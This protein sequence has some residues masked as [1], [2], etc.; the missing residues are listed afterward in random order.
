MSG[1]CEIYCYLSGKGNLCVL[2]LCVQTESIVHFANICITKS[3]QNLDNWLDAIVH[4][5]SSD[6][7]VYFWSTVWYPCLVFSKYTCTS[8][9]HELFD[10]TVLMIKDICL[11]EVTLLHVVNNK[12]WIHH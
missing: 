1:K 10:L 8:N 7:E 6:S 12:D 3:E 2:F 9:L 11:T 5:F 4:A